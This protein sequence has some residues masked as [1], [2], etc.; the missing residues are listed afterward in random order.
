L[1]DAHKIL[2]SK[3]ERERARRR[4]EYNIKVDFRQIRSEDMGFIQRALE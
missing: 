1:E 3:P 2:I 4:R